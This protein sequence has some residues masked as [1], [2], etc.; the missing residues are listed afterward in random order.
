MNMGTSSGL[1]LESC[2]LICSNTVHFLCSFMDYRNSRWSGNV[3]LVWVSCFSEPR[4]HHEMI[5]LVCGHYAGAPGTFFSVCSMIC[6]VGHPAVSIQ[7]LLCTHSFSLLCPAF[8]DTAPQRMATRT[9]PGRVAAF[10]VAEKVFPFSP[11]L[12]VLKLECGQGIA[13]CTAPVSGAPIRPFIEM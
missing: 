11:P 5:L 9:C 6:S 4:V 3:M 1:L 10:S 7:T 13:T 12:I 2:C 8:V